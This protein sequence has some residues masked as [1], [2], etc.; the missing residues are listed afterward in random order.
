MESKIIHGDCIDEL[1]K[2]PD[3]SVDLV[4]TDPPFFMKLDHFKTRTF[5]KRNFADIG[6]IENFFRDVFQQIFR[7][8]KPTG[9][10]YC[11]CD[12]QSYPLFWYHI[13]QYTKS[14]R[15]LIWNKK[16]SI[17]G[18][19]WRHQHEL[20]IFAEMPQAKPVPTGDGDILECRAVPVGKRIHPAEK[21]VELLKKFIEKSSDEN[22]IVLDPFAGSGSVMK[23][24]IE[25]NRKYIMIEK[26][27]SY[28]EL[29]KQSDKT[30]TSQTSLNPNTKQKA[31]FEDLK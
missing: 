2:L 29:M 14:A 7:V 25:T 12:G 24:C 9:R 1:K 16:T 5:F 28:F 17:N 23:A 15:P 11:F 21:P 19:S 20:I 22:D 30:S 8:L 31:G 18:Y 3:A 13:F 27:S 4:V 10:M 6:I 26:E